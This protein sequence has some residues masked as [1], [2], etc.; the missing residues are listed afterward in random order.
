MGMILGKTD[1]DELIVIKE[2][3]AGDVEDFLDQAIN[4]ET[5]Q[6][7]MDQDGGMEHAEEI[8]SQI[9]QQDQHLLGVPEALA[10][11]S[12]EETL[13]IVSNIDL[14]SPAQIIAMAEF[15]GRRAQVRDNK[16][17]MLEFV[18]AHI[19]PAQGEGTRWDTEMQLLDGGG[20]PAASW[21]DFLPVLDL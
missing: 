13:L 7:C 21:L 15:Q 2:Q 16:Q 14:S 11:V 17:G 20:H 8:V 6:G 9:I 4:T 1:F 18:L 5:C 10:T 19:Q 3:F 12:E